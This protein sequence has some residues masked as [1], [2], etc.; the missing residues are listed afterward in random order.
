M[1]S[2]RR[3]GWCVL[4][5]IGVLNS[6]SSLSGGSSNRQEPEPTGNANGLPDGWTKSV[7][8][9]S[10]PEPGKS[11]L[12]S[13]ANLRLWTEKGWLLVRRERQEGVEWQIVLARATDPT[14]PVVAV[15]KD[16]LS[17][18]VTYG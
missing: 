2:W 18:D 1:C 4:F 17:V 13:A 12:V 16:N 15:G 9:A 8:L 3:R 11:Q 10:S 14:P 5:L 6:A 7:N